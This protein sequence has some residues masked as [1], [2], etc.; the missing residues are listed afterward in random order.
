MLLK[1]LTTEYIRLYKDD[2]TKI[3]WS[4]VS[5]SYDFTID[6]LR[7]FIDYIDWKSYFIYHY[8]HSQTIPEAMEFKDKHEDWCWMWT[9]CGGKPLVDREY[10]RR[11]IWEIVEYDNTWRDI[12]KAQ[13]LD[14]EFL[15][16]Y[17]KYIEWDE[18]MDLFPTWV[19]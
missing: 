19:L 8:H 2:K 5:Y 4:V 6:Q 9:K 14:K 11:W 7:E 18:I 12:T 17:A 13:K 10:V 1:D 16:P 3:N 15:K